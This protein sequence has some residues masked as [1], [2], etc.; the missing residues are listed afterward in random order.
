LVLGELKE[1]SKA[2]ELVL[3]WEVELLELGLVE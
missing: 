1:L 3:E 2:E